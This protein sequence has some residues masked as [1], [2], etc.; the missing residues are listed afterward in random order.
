MVYC[1]P[2]THRDVL[3]ATANKG[4]R[5]HEFVHKV[6][7]KKRKDVL[8]QFTDGDIQALIA[9]HCLDEGV[10]IPA[11]DH[12]LILA[13][14]RNPR[15]FIQR[16]GRVL[17]RYEGKHL[18]FLHDALVLPAMS[19]DDDVGLS[20]VRGELSRAIQF[21]RGAKNPSSVTE[22][23]RIAVQFGISPEDF[24]DEGVEDE[25]SDE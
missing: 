10:D 15:E 3:A 11:A 23:E 9:V 16:R 18:S 7:M 4:L 13:S 14:S 24:E 8:Q 6:S 2:G 5:C 20:I 19:P 25:N 22:L 21:G 12:A 17:R 1:A